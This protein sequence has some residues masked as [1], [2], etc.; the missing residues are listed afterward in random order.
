M[1]SCVLSSG[2]L[3]WVASVEETRD[4][5]KHPAHSSVFGL[6]VAD[7]ITIRVA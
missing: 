5:H 4:S 1:A 7:Y 3:P 6:F 2:D